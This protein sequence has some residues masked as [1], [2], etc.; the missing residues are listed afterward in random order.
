MKLIHAYIQPHKLSDV[1]LA[2]RGVSGLSGM[3][4]IDVR[5]WGRGKTLDEE[6]HREE[7]VSDFEKHTKL[8]MCC[9]DAVADQVL[10]AIRSGAHTGLRGDGLILVTDVQDAVRISTGERGQSAC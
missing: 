4:V 5:G 2:L 9:A 6:N 1:T 3:T 7:R 10:E 8:E